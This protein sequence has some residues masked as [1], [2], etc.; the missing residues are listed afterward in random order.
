V[1]LFA[2]LIGIEHEGVP[3]AGVASL[4]GL[5]ERV[6]ARRGEAARWR[7]RDGV[8]VDARVSQTRELGGAMIEAASATAF[9]SRDLGH[10]YM[11]L[12]EGAKKL[13]G[14]SEGAAFAFVATGRV[15]AAVS[16]G[17]SRWDVSAYVPIVEAAGGRLTSW[18][19]GPAVDARRMIASNGRMH[20]RVA[21]IVASAGS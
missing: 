13:R 9:V 21:A 4:P 20:E 11:S 19:G 5:G 18:E 8:V 7:R 12:A 1:A 3:V 16:I 2:I 10:V 17:M 15:D 6:W 14:W